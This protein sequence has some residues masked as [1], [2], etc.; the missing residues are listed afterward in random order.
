M[1]HSYRDFA[2]KYGRN[3]E[4]GE[5]MM[6]GVGFYLADSE[7]EAIR[8]FRIQ[9]DERFKWFAPFGFVRYSDDQGRPWGTP[10]LQPGFLTWKMGWLKRRGSAAH[11]RSS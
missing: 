9:H 1:V 5:D 7:E 4:L 10:G 8:R 11:R 2:A 3:L 6:L